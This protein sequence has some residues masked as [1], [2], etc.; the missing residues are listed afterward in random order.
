MPALTFPFRAGTLSYTNVYAF[1]Q[2]L[3]TS[4][5]HSH[6]V[7]THTGRN[8]ARIYIFGPVLFGGLEEALFSVKTNEHI[9][10]MLLNHLEQNDTTSKLILALLGHASISFPRPARQN[11]NETSALYMM[12]I[13]SHE[14]SFSFLMNRTSEPMELVLVNKVHKYVEQQMK[15]V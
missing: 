5:Y 4:I 6:N 12:A 11:V 2:P 8:V 9:W 15:F 13:R 3:G 1:Q 7:H 10:K 14:Y